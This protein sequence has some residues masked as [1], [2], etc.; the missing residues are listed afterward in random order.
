MTASVRHSV[1]RWG[2]GSIVVALLVLS[3]GCGPRKEVAELDKIIPWREVPLPEPPPDGLD[4]T[5]RLLIWRDY[6]D[7]ELLDYF[8]DHYGVKFEITYFETNRELRQIVEADPDGYDIYMP[9]SYVVQDFVQRGIVAPLDKTNIPNMGNIAAGFYQAPYDPDLAHSVPLFFSY[10]GVA[11]NGDYL[12]TL[13]KNFQ[14]ISENAEENTLLY[15]YRALLD[16]ARTTLATNLL[17][18][19]YDPN[20]T[21]PIELDETTQHLIE[22]TTR[23]G[24]RYLADEVP[25]ALAKNEILI[26]TCW[27]GAAGYALSLNHAIRFFLPPGPKF[28]E[29]DSMVI[30][31]NSPHQATAEF[32]LNYLLIPEVSGAMSNYSFYANTNEPSRPFIDRSILLGPSYVIAPRGTSIFLQDL[33]DFEHIYVSQWNRLK[34]SVSEVTTKVP[35]RLS[36]RDIS[37]GEDVIIRK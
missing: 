28:I 13:P 17:A 22:A 3:V 12:R 14:L 6:L 37:Q 7:P 1:R 18:E 2:F 31:A 30:A 34:A 36:P 33:G 16:E 32:F 8:S 5:L 9:S 23:D 35:L 10:L 27:S 25:E 24:I 29:I 15:G 19:G 20:S 26:S 21:D 4:S 11:F